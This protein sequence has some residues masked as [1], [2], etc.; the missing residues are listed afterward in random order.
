MENQSSLLPIFEYLMKKV[1][2]YILHPMEF[3]QGP[4]YLLWTANSGGITTHLRQN[5][6]VM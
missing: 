4:F 3:L 2:F 5:A 1:K 6:D